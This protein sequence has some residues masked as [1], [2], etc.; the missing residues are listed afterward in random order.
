MK[1]TSITR[2]FSTYFIILFFSTSSLIASTPNEGEPDNILE[3]YI[4]K[5]YESIN[6]RGNKVKYD[7]FAKGLKGFLLLKSKGQLSAERD[8]ITIIDFSQTSK[9][10]RLWV[11]DLQDRR[12]LYN[13]LVAHG[14]NTGNEFANNFSNIPQSFQSSLGFYVTGSTYHGKHGLS[15]YLNG[16]EKGINDN[17]KNR[18]IVMHGANYVS[19][20]FISKYGRL[21][22]SLGC[23]AVPMTN[24]KQIIG[25]ISNKTCLF[26]YHPTNT[27]Q[28]T[29]SILKENF[30]ISSSLIKNV[31]GNLYSSVNVVENAE[32]TE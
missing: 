29:S 3:S 8:I 6:F 16:K 17:A 28:R 5:V 22:R 11:I 14:R 15:L 18:A 1:P 27:Y 31:F 21:G 2:I 9:N 7:I 25:S 4:H 19:R 32:V 13:S 30:P 20:D 10:N 23:P 24:Y 12:L 26:I